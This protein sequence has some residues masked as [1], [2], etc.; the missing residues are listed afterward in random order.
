MFA[1]A[2]LSVGAL[3]LYGGVATGQTPPPI[4]EDVV[5]EVVVTGSRIPIPNDVAISP[6]TEVTSA[7]IER[8]GVTRIEDLLNSLPQVVAD[9]GST[10]SNGA[11]GTAAV[12]LRGFGSGRTL[13]LV[14]GRRLGPGD[15]E[16]GSQ[17]DLNQIPVEL[18]NSIEI[19]T[20]GASS[21]YGADAVAGVVNFKLIDHF[22]GFKVTANYGFYN[23][24]NDNTDGVND[25]IV[26]DNFSL[27]PTHVDTGF[28]KDL[29]LL[30]GLDTPNGKGNGMFYA[31]YRNI[32]AVLQSQ[33]SYSACGFGVRLPCLARMPNGGKFQCFGSGTSYPGLFKTIDPDSGTT[34]PE[35][36]IGPHGNL[37][38]FTPARIL[39]T[40]LPPTIFSDLTSAIPGARFFITR[41]MNTPPR[42]QKS[43][44]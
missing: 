17:S 11:D 29:S 16:G 6:V 2:A 40:P 24:T 3:V 12:N 41:L 13:V 19:L 43:S 42:I 39:I 18:I 34:G 44:T 8:T 10:V 35:Q 9:Q 27:A 7:L 31:T 36:T 5:A 26:R 4:S 37:I 28:T 1:L 25:A 32:A 23:H 33:Y 15:P 21:V 38:P 20:G 14:N 22:E 30:A